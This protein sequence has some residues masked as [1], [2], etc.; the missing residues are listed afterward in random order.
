MKNVK[1]LLLNVCRVDNRS[2]LKFSFL[3]VYNVTSPNS[4]SMLNPNLNSN[5]NRLITNFKASTL[6]ASLDG[7]IDNSNKEEKANKLEK[8]C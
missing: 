3:L 5:S 2:N 4:H 7:S 8:S 6:F 1:V